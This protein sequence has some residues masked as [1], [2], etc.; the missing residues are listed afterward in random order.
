MDRLEA[1]RLFVR[2]VESGSFSAVAREVGVGQPAISKQIAALEATLGARLLQRTSRSLTLT[3]AGRTCYEA[4][5][6]LV[7]DF[8]TLQSSVGHGQASPSGLVRLSAAPVFGRLHIVPQLERFLARH[9]AITIEISASSRRLNLTEEGL[10][11]AIR[12]GPLTDRSLTARKLTTIPFITVASAA[13]LDRA[14]TPMTPDDLA[15]HACVIFSDGGD[16]RPW[17][18]KGAQGAFTHIP[19]GGLRTSDGEQIRAAVLAGL[20]LAHGPAWVFAPEIAS[21][22]VR[23]VLTEYRSGVSEVSAVYP[24]QRR[25]P[26]RVRLFID[27]LA[28]IFAD[29]GWTRF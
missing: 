1:L 20:G 12:H 7:D 9:P 26:A 8:A 13:Y 24:S 2:V 11:L 18:F 4:A 27:F 15:H 14:G 10:D 5:L 19:T 3:D 25:L 29:P 6:R 17:P 21:G 22:T 28:E 16:V 23:A